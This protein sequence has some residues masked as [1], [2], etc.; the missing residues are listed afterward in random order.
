MLLVPLDLVAS[1]D[2]VGAVVGAEPPAGGLSHP[3]SKKAA[4]RLD[5][6]RTRFMHFSCCDV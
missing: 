1:P 6:I 2:G 5:E 4:I 3:T